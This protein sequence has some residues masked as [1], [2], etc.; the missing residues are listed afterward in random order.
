MLENIHTVTNVSGREAECGKSEQRKGSMYWEENL[1]WSGKVN[2]CGG[3]ASKIKSYRQSGDLRLT[4]KRTPYMSP[5]P[6]TLPPMPSFKAF[7]FN[8]FLWNY[9]DFM[10]LKGDY[11]SQK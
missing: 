2:V 1:K 8:S 6:P 9:H 10:E 5:A 4:D 7:P 11:F 3:K